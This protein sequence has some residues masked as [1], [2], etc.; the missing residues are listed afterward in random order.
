MNDLLLALD[1]GTQSVRALIFDPIGTLVAR[2]Q[3]VIQPYT[4]PRP[5]WAEQDPD[6]YWRAMGEACAALWQEHDP[7]SIAG[8]AL[9][10]Q[11]AT[12]VAVDEHGQPLRDAIVWLDQRRATGLPSVGGF[13][14]LAFRLAGVADTVAAFQAAAPDNWLASQQ[15]QLWARVDKMLL[16]SGYLTWRLCGR[17]ADAVAAQVG[18][19]PFDYKRRQWA[20]PGDWKWRAVASRRAQLPELVPSGQPIGGLT[21]EAAA[22]LGLAANLP[23]IAAG[24]A[25]ASEVLGSGCVTPDTAC[26]SFG[27]TATVNTCRSRYLEATRHVPPY[28][29]AM[30]DAYNNEMQI[31]RG[32]WLVSWFKQQ[33]GVDAQAQA[34][35]RGVAVEALF[36][37]AIADIPAGSMGLI[38][39][40]TWS[41]GVR[42]PGPEAKGAVIGFGD[43]H[44]RAHFYRAILEGLVYGLREGAENIQRRGR[45]RLR[46]LRVAGGGSQSDQAMQITADVFGMPAER[47]HVYEA[48]GLGAAINV[49]VGL[50][51]HPDHRTAVAAMTRPGAV[52]T[53]E[54]AAVRV[55]DQLY[56]DV[57][58]RLYRR[59]KPLYRSIREITGYPP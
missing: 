15:P 1:V 30:P 48:S 9:T 39:Q 17:W 54:P 24:A 20:K 19:I 21:A 4:A 57:Y 28:P 53:P 56:N 37:E 13:W 40:P 32:F 29:A 46:S 45:T 35:A 14:G 52:F 38:L 50:G 23:L 47:P 34:D 25:K 7:A 36:D 10:T 2:A 59:L 5:G 22:Q 44:S 11:R 41:P 58:L 43:V 8:L 49:A 16:L 18:Y 26:L 6:V 3:I 42:V 27:T 33:F 12:A 55:Y 31:Y 51:L